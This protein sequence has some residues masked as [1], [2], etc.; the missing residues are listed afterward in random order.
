[1]NWL[2]R[3]QS[4]VD[5]DKKPEGWEKNLWGEFFALLHR[6]NMWK[7]FE[8]AHDASPEDAKRPG[9]WLRQW[10]LRN[11]VETQAVAIRRIADRSTHPNTVSLGRLLDEIGAH[12]EVLG[13]AVSA[14]AKQDVE[15]LAEEARKVRTFATKVVAHLD[16]DHA[17]AS[18][19]ATFGDFD[20]AIEFISGLWAKWYQTITQHGVAI[21]LPSEGWEN[22]LRFRHRNLSLDNAALVV[23]RLI[24]EQGPEL[25]REL[26]DT[27]LRTKADRVNLAGR[28]Y[29]DGVDWLA[30]L[31]LELENEIDDR[32]RDRIVAEVR[33][34][35]AAMP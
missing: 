19:D 10:V 22:V 24:Y 29:G 15:A 7:G 6:R 21:L 18:Q 23:G 13:S 31:L 35:L 12:P 25:A 14:D 33:R 1:V 28:L 20:R 2:D 30:D 17:A 26:A 11:H 9:R 16:S 34:V 32:A 8:Q 5:P 4:W 3:W 27:L